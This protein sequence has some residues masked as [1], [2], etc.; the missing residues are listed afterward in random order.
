VLPNEQ[1]LPPA[2]QAERRALRARDEPREW[3]LTLLSLGAAA[4]VFAAM[5]TAGRRRDDGPAAPT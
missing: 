3:A 5:A 1:A 2:R 4:G